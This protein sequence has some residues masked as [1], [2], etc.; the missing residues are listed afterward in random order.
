MNFNTIIKLLTTE[1]PEN[2]VQVKADLTSLENNYL[3]KLIWVYQEKAF[4]FLTNV[5]GT[6]L[7]N[8]EKLQSNTKINLYDNNVTYQTGEIVFYN[9]GVVYYSLV[10]DNYQ[11]IPD[12]SPD[13]WKLLIDS[14]VFDTT[15]IPN[16]NLNEPMIDDVGDIPAGTTVGDLADTPLSLLIYKMLFPLKHAYV[17][18][19]PDIVL[20]QT[21]FEPLVVGREYFL[22]VGFSTIWGEIMNGDN[23]P[24]GTNVLE[25]F[26]DDC[27]RDFDGNQLVKDSG[28]YK[29]TVFEGIK[30]YE[31][32]AD[33][34]SQTDFSDVYDSK[35]NQEDVQL[36]QIYAF[37]KQWQI[38]GWFAVWSRRG[39]DLDLTETLNPDSLGSDDLEHVA[40][41]NG[42]TLPLEYNSIIIWT[43]DIHPP[44]L[45]QINTGQTYDSTSSQTVTI[46]GYTY[47]KYLYKNLPEDEKYAIYPT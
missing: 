45:K 34:N 27:A 47:Y 42:I 22:D 36:Q 20:N 33:Y 3:G 2:Q 17:G 40:T 12:Q 5:D 13:K 26:I 32:C 21:L 23:T 10:D 24:S 7:S 19:E 31:L 8:W 14:A 15:K 30:T 28:K 46:Y 9:N 18:T 29:V 39:K 6:I 37:T 43:R 44:K 35:G 11:N 38:T 16:V 4:Y 25:S 41:L 1:E